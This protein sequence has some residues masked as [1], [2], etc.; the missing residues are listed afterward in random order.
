MEEKDKY[1]KLCREEDSISI[2][3]KDWWL[4]A[5]CGED[6]WDVVIIE[7]N[8]VIVAA[9]PYKVSHRY[10][11]TILDM[12]QLTQ[13]IGPWLRY[14]AN[15]NKMKK[16]SFERKYFDMLLD[17]MPEYDFFMQ[18]TRYTIDNWLPFY[19]KGFKAF[20]CYTYVID[21]IEDINIAV[22][23]FNP[24]KKADLK[25]A[26][27]SNIIIKYDL[28]SEEFYQHHSMILKQR[29][30]KIHYSFELLK[31]IY[32]SV[33]HNSSGRV[34][35]AVDEN[36]NIHVANL[37][38]WDRFSGYDLISTI[39]KNYRS[40][41]A[42]TLLIKE[43]INY[44]LKLGIKRYDFEGSMIEGVEHSYRSF[45]STRKLYYHLTK[46]NSKKYQFLWNLREAFKALKGQ[47]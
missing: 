16:D 46:I 1:R 35:Y 36:D 26:N 11:M 18:H 9:W 39:D 4:D 28:S 8:K 24:K 44:M 3:Q 7:E 19:W 23:N 38:I 37:F 2:F 47:I 6:N 12:P 10:G 5:V 13:F 20:P 22:N 17:K 27:I 41:G 29:G 43:M 14:P 15:Q 40:S 33:Y 25:K 32:D 45:G 42:T 21:N 31:K 34:I 30:E